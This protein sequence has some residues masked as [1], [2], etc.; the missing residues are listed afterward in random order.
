MNHSFSN[1]PSFAS[2]LGSTK[3]ISVMGLAEGSVSGLSYD[4]RTVVAGDLFFALPGAHQNG[5][6][7]VEDAVERGA[8]GVVTETELPPLP[9]PVIRVASARKAMADIA[10]RYY[11]LPSATLAVAGVTGTNGKTTTAWI[12]RHLCDAV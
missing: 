5:A 8:I 6:R 12:I 4:S 2:L 9:I 11:D 7:F 3:V 1:T 10:A